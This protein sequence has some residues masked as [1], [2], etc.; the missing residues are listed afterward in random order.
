MEYIKK[1]LLPIETKRLIL[2]LLDPEEANIMVSYLLENRE[3]LRKWEPTRSEKYFNAD[4]WRQELQNRENAF[5]IGEAANLVIFPKEARKSLILG[6]CNFTNVM[7]GAF[8]ACH[9]GYSIHKDYEG[10]GIMFEALSAATDF[11]SSVFN[12][13]RIIA[14]YMPR[15]ERSGLLLKRLGFTVEGF[16]RDYLEINGK[17][18]DHILTSKIF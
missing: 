1:D 15:N 16:A 12:L 10:K 4:Y 7:Y 14:N 18:E 17:W 3:H 5:Y 13:H 8:R 11:V 2:R 9:L 6:V